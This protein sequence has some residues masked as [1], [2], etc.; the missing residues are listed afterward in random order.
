M[1]RGNRNKIVV[2]DGEFIGINLGADYTAEHE[3]GLEDLKRDF[4]FGDKDAISKKNIGLKARTMTVLPEG[5]VFKKIGKKTYLIYGG[6]WTS[7]CIKRNGNKYFTEQRELRLYG[8]STLA[9]AWSGNDFGILVNTPDGRIY[10]KELYKAFLNKDVAFMFDGS[11]PVKNPGLCLCIA[12]KLPKQIDEDFK[13]ADLDKIKLTKAVAKSGIEK[14]L[15]AA[16]TQAGVAER[17][18]QP[19][20]YFALSP[21]WMP[22]E[23][24]LK[25]ESRYPL[26]FWLNPM[27]QKENNCGWFTVEEL[28]AWTRGEGPIPKKNEG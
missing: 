12:S 27:Q 10:L 23:G 8:E 9:T 19:Y 25:K 7:D 17:W 14:F 24:S 13:A 21:R 16:S 11:N 26:L 5:L 3:F 20:T 15:Q 1:R 18:S 4:G 28:M 2:I 6:C 22:K